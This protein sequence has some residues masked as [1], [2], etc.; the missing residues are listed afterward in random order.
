MANQDPQPEI[1]RVNAAFAPS[2][3]AGTTSVTLS[4]IHI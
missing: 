4:L 3:T 2:T 1:Y